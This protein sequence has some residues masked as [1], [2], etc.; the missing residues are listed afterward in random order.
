MQSIRVYVLLALCLCVSSSLWSQDSPYNGEQREIVAPASLTPP[1]IA[2]TGQ[3]DEAVRFIIPGPHGTVIFMKRQVVL[4][5]ERT[6]DANPTAGKDYLRLLPDE[7]R[8]AALTR[9]I[10][11]LS[12][13]AEVIRIVFVKGDPEAAIEGVDKQPTW[14]NHLV[15][16]DSSKWARGIPMFKGVAYRSVW[17]GVDLIF[18]VDG[19]KITCTPVGNDLDLVEFERTAN[20]SLGSD[21]VGETLS[22]ALGGRWTVRKGRRVMLDRQGVFVTGPVY[23]PVS[24]SALDEPS[25]YTANC[26]VL[27]ADLSSGRPRWIT[28]L[29]GGLQDSPNGVA[30][31]R[32]G[33]VYLTGFTRSADFPMAVGDWGQYF[34]AKLNPSGSSLARSTY[35]T[36]GGGGLGLETFAT[37]WMTHSGYKGPRMIAIV[38]D[39]GRDEAQI[40]PFLDL[41]IPVT[42]AVM[43]WVDPTSIRRIKSRG[44]AAFLHAPMEALGSV[45]TRSEEITIGQTAAQVNELLESWL[46]LTPGVV[47]ISNHRGSAATSDPQT[48]RYVAAFAKKHGLFLYDSN[49]SPVSIA[50]NIGRE[51]GV[52][53]MQQDFFLDEREPSLVRARLLAMADLAE[54][55][56]YATCICHV[57]RPVVP[58]TIRAMIPELRARGFRFVTV[59]ELHEALTKR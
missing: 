55:T 29:G 17:P 52:P 58:E 45:N 39:D 34:S 48:M 37:E 31:D 53:C 10:P 15:G 47:G 1:V 24:G 40:K 9:R 43:P 28:I 23:T 41:G 13:P 8:E 25:D 14:A 32:H 20:Q 12:S 27:S 49:T 57:G 26:F 11:S 56:G 22:S 38:I 4:A 2:N 46:A 50:V 3:F 36:S 19:G 21:E 44:C 6:D 35:L 30:V 51:M 33:Y 18:K 42:F 5:L 16:N 54:R 7:V 59:P